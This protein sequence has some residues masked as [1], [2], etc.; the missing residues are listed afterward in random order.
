MVVAADLYRAVTGGF[1]QETAF[2]T[3]LDWCK[4]RGHDWK[5]GKTKTKQIRLSN[6]ERPRAYLLPPLADPEADPKLPNKARDYW[7]EMLRTKTDTELG[8]IYETKGTF[9]NTFK[10]NY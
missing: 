5:D 8:T 4:K 2:D 10:K 7:L 1:K 9:K 3:V 6:G